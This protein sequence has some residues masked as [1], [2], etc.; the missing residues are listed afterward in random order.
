[1]PPGALFEL[2]ISD[3]RL[4]I[5]PPA[6]DGRAAPKSAIVNRSVPS[7]DVWLRVAPARDRRIAWI[8]D[9]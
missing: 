3:F 9:F 4:A 2:A 8:G 5:E 1:M 6:R 7:P